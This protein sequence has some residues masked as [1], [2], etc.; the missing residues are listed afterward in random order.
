MK[1][2]KLRSNILLLFHEGEASMHWIEIIVHWVPVLYVD[3][4]QCKKLA[5]GQRSSRD[6]H[7][8]R[9]KAVI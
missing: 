7:C 2:N 9:T 4:M 8:I 1:A 6:L 5:Q 3:S